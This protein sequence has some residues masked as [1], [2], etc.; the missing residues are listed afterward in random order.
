[1]T[2]QEMREMMLKVVSV[3][4]ADLTD[5]EVVALYTTAT[6]QKD[7]RG[8]LGAEKI[9]ELLNQDGTMHDETLQA[10][11]KVAGQRIQEMQRNK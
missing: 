5:T 6:W 8:K 4:C 7:F 1:M 3:A 11:L 10:F 2:E 9:T